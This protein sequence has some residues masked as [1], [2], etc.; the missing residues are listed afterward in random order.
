M[1]MM[2]DTRKP[3]FGIYGRGFIFGSLWHFITKCER[4]HCK[5]RQLFYYKMRQ[6]CITECIRLFITKCNS[7]MTKFDNY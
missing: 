6:K 2:L 1:D 7:F 4:Y 5:M 3:N